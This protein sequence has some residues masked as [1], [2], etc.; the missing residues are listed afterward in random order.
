MQP[1]K[2]RHL[3]NNTTQ[4]LIYNFKEVPI[5]SMLDFDYV[6]RRS[7]PSIAGLIKPGCSMVMHHKIFF[8]QEEIMLPIYG[9]IS[10]AIECQPQAKVFINYASHRSAYDSSLEALQYNTIQCVVIIAEGIPESQSKRLRILSERLGKIV[11]GPATVGGLQAG[12]FKIGDAAGSIDNVIESKLYRPGSIGLI[13]KSGGLSNEMYR[14][15]SIYTNGIFEGIAIG[16]DAYP[17]STMLSHALRFETIPEIKMIVILGEIGGTSELEVAEAIKNKRITKPVAAWVTGT[18]ASLFP[19]EVQ[20]GH[21][22][23]KSGVANESAQAKN[24]ALKEA[25]ALVPDCFNQFALLIAKE[26]KRLVDQGTIIPVPIYNPQFLPENYVNMMREGRIRRA[27]GIVST[28]C[29]DRGDEPTYAGI[30][31]SEI[32]QEQM[33]IGD[34][35]SLLWFKCRLPQ[36]AT[37]FIEICMILVADHGPCVSGA[38]NTIVAARAGKD[39]VSCLTSGLLTIGPRFGGAIDNA[40]RQFKHACDTGI[41]PDEF[42]ESKKAEGQL[43]SGIGHR[44]KSQHNPDRRVQILI[45]YATKS[46]SSLKYLQYAQRVENYTLKKASN[47]ILNVDGVIAVLFLDLMNSCASFDNEQIEEMIE[48]GFFNSLFILGRSIGLIGHALDQKRLKQPLYRHPWDDVMYYPI[49]EPNTKKKEDQI[50]GLR[51]NL[52]TPNLQD[53]T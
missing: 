30:S 42:V 37:R 17:G 39:I 5:Q 50:G 43:I 32:I 23:A 31:V 34:V 26:Y 29:N 13:T 20:F 14:L 48:I 24:Q 9:S 41:P 44:V 8:G 3:F 40:A 27:T 52:S 1:I 38:H 28:I 7:I 36:Y 47:L 22:G 11:I 25:G 35:I 19:T 51:V 16:G 33:S 4:S 46:F 18:C 2:P 53:L 10:K 12:A 49:A 45:E 21:A 15:L 6:S